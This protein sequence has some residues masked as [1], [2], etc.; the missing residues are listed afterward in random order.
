MQASDLQRAEK[1]ALAALDPADLAARQAELRQQRDLMFR[2]ERKAKR[3]AK[4]KS[5]AFR[6]IHRRSKG[7]EDGAGLSLDDMA[8]LDRIDGGDRVTEE[9]ARME[10]VRAHERATLKHSTKGGRWSKTV[11][12]IHGLDEERNT[13]VRQMVQRGEELRRKIAGADGDESDDGYGQE[14]SEEEDDAA[15][16]DRIRKTAF[17]ELASL[18]ARDA[19]AAAMAPALKGV[20]NMKFMKDAMARGERKVQTEADELRRKLDL[21]DDAARQAEDS[22]GDDEET[23]ALS[24]Q[25]DGNLGRMVFGPSAGSRSTATSSTILLPIP[26]QNTIHT[27]KLTA[28]LSI[29]SSAAS[30]PSTS[31]SLLSASLAPEEEANPWLAVGEEHAGGK[32]SRKMNK[33]IVGKDS[34]DAARSVARVDRH[35]A[36]QADVREDEQNDAQ[37][38]LDLQVVLAPAKAAKTPQL[39]A[40]KKK[41]QQKVLENSSGNLATAVAKETQDM[42]DSSEDEDNDEAQQAQRGRGPTAFKQRDLVAKAFAG[43]N[44]IAVSLINMLSELLS[45]LAEV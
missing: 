3:V 43:D 24:E 27:T 15:D 17:D 39:V 20:L 42:D 14:S 38:E 44:V 21:M 22:S 26:A 33:A 29:S 40:P 34:R 25:V 13:A 6:R 9:K 41:K 5:K 31:H 30:R 28:P 8:E 16:M 11:G 32:I 35:K 2:A 1:A 19:E 37:V 7:K 4:I 12:D 23:T 10:V 18:D 36:K 45:R